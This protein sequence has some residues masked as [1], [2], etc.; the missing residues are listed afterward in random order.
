[1]T[2][3]HSRDLQVCLNADVD[4]WRTLAHCAVQSGRQHTWVGSHPHCDETMMHSAWSLLGLSCPEA[5]LM[6]DDVQGTTRIEPMPAWALFHI[7]PTLEVKLQGKRPS[8]DHPDHTFLP[9]TAH[10]P[11]CHCVTP[12]LKAISACCSSGARAHASSGSARTSTYKYL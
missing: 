6:G 2:L 11:V 12:I 9:H 10:N 8:R 3:Q 4:L 5:Y 7:Q 1:M